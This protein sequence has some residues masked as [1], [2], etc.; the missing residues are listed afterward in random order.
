M[1]DTVMIDMHAELGDIVEVTADAIVNAANAELWMGS[2]VAGA[3]KARGGAGI[4]AEALRQG[5][6]KRGEA[7]VTSSGR[8]SNCRYVIHAAAMGGAQWSPDAESIYRATVAALTRADELGL[9]TVAF[10]ALGTGVGGFSLQAAATQMARATRDFAT[11][12]PSSSLDAVRFILRD[13][14]SLDEFQRG[15]PQHPLA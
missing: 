1:L 4:E 11:R 6:I 12:H 2:G 13:Q 7:V 15:L 3:I 8:L 14:A 9:V 5:P 10:P